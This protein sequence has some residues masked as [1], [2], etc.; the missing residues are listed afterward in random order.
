MRKIL[1]F[2][3]LLVATMAYTQVNL[4]NFRLMSDDL[5]K[6]HA[7]FNGRQTNPIPDWLKV[8]GVKAYSYYINFVIPY[9]HSVI[10]PML[11]YR[12][13]NKGDQNFLD[14]NSK[15]AKSIPRETIVPLGYFASASDNGA[16]SKY[17]DI[18]NG[19]YT[20]TYGFIAP[21]K[22]FDYVKSTG[23]DAWLKH[24]E[25]SSDLDLS[26][27]KVSPLPDSYEGCTIQR[28]PGYWQGHVS[29]GYVSGISQGNGLYISITLHD[30][31]YPDEHVGQ[32][33]SVYYD[34]SAPQ[35]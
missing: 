9:G 10:R 3:M 8:T 5:Q 4:A 22:D 7:E 19:Y 1:V 6:Y 17:P 21:K 18:K 20:Y 29:F 13:L 34:N 33:I 30:A 32:Y 31:D 26:L 14:V 16:T 12:P 35:N 24:V 15:Y 2:I 25:A 28:K 11:V 27:L 23:L